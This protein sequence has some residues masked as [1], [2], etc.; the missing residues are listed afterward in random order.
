MNP[1]KRI[2]SIL[3]VGG[4]TSGWIAAGYLQ[5]VLNPPGTN[6]PVAITLVESED[7]GIIGVGEATVPTLAETMSR[8][9][10]PER[11]FLRGVDGSIKMAI[12]FR[13]W[14][15]G[16]PT[17]SY[18][19]PFGYPQTTNGLYPAALWQTGRFNSG[20]KSYADALGPHA[21]LCDRCLAPKDSGMQDYESPFNYA[22]HIDAVKFGR[23]LRGVLVERGVRHLVDNVVGTQLREDGFLRAVTTEKHGELEADLF[24]DC[25]GFRG[26]L[27]NQLYQSPF[28][29][30]GDTLINDRAVAM[31][32][33][34][35]EGTTTIRSYTRAT[36][37]SS[38][39]VW[40]ISLHKRRGI[41][42]VYSSAFQSDEEAANILRE[43]IG[44]ESRGREP[45][46]L[47]MRI[48]YNQRCWQ[49][50][51]VAV[52][53]SG[54][55][56][57]PL[58]S[59]GIYLI[60]FGMRYLLEHFPDRDFDPALSNAYNEHVHNAYEEIHDFILTHYILTQREDTPYWRAYRHEIKVP[61][62]LAERLKLWRSRWPSPADIPYRHFFFTHDS[63]TFILA[64]MGHLPRTPANLEG[65]YQKFGPM[66]DEWY[67]QRKQL[68]AHALKHL[69]SHYSYLRGIHEESSAT[70]G[71]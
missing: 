21:A 50:N 4:G 59:T 3:I 44:P 35:A 52:G 54:G 8:F 34:H 9:N 60:E 62:R 51:V 40:D 16:N 19:H 5:S 71:A 70:A 27:V 32:I 65:F 12:Q 2:R 11:D 39:W 41:G 26:L 30:F 64:G 29:S 58:E 63:W 46:L 61:D 13:E 36:A 33:P 23:F 10:I 69:P 7:I 67:K 55:F 24:I 6:H 56:L 48:G 66:A 28:I 1:E 37:R 14:K 68:E 18:W 17:E 43:Y 38:G 53:L 57:E 49:K 20:Q 42:Y 15:T 47:K 45:R 25:T 31:Q 22:Y